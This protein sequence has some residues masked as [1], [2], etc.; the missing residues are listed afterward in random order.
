MEYSISINHYSNYSL[1][2]ETFS[3]ST[4][5]HIFNQQKI[6]AENLENAKEVIRKKLNFKKLEKFD[7]LPVEIWSG[8]KHRRDFTFETLKEI[9]K[10]YK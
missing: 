3:Y 6:S 10:I 5:S 9:T 1:I 4:N 2:M 8:E 7:M